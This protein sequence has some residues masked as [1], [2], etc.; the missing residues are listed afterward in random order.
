MTTQNFIDSLVL[1]SANIPDLAGGSKGKDIPVG[2]IQVCFTLCSRVRH[3]S[4]QPDEQN[5]VYVHSLPSSIEIL[6]H[7][8]SY[9]L[10]FLKGCGKAKSILGALLSEALD[11]EAYPYLFG[12]SRAMSFCRSQAEQLARNNLSQILIFYFLSP[13][14][15]PVYDAGIWASLWIYLGLLLYQ[16]L[17]GCCLH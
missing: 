1:N 15:D 6:Q 2:R 16:N 7:Y 14:R 13:C 3:P 4:E 5:M 10:F 8:H 11:T 9:H 12:V 17:R